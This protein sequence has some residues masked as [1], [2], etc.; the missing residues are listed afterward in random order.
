MKRKIAA[1]LLLVMLLMLTACKS[2]PKGTDFQTVQKNGEPLYVT[3]YYEDQIIRVRDQPFSGA[4]YDSNGNLI[5]ELGSTENEDTYRYK[6]DD[7]DLTIYYPNEAT[8]W[9]S[10]SADGAIGGWSNDYDPERYIEGEV[11]A[12][13]IRA[14][15]DAP[16]GNPDAVLGVAVLSLVL[17][18]MGIFM[19]KDPEA[20]IHMKYAIRF[21]YVE[22]T[23]FALAEIRIAGVV[24]IAVAVIA[25]LLAAF[26]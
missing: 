18:L 11:L 2:S 23:D 26:G 22:P 20:V 14:A 10:E 8:W 21:H 3:Y 25:F 15:Y 16:S 13:Q 1:L 5:A 7:G 19:I 6:Y 9:E 12:R 4:A 17:I 24:A